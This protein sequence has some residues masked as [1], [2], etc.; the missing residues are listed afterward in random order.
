MNH[1]QPLALDRKFARIFH[2]LF[3]FLHIFLEKGN[4]A[5][6]G[7]LRIKTRAIL[8]NRKD[9]PAKQLELL[10]FNRNNTV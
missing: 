2:I 7:D 3:F 8:D 9:E 10:Q 6:V 4:L 5:F 1:P